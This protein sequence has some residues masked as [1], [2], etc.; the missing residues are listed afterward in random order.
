ME[1]EKVFFDPRALKRF[2]EGPLAPK[3]DGFCEW[4]SNHG[5]ARSTIRRHISR[6][7]SFS[8][9]LQK[10]KLTILV[11]VNSEHIQGVITGYLL[12]CK[13]RCPGTKHYHSVVY[14]IHRFIDYL[15]ECGFVNAV[16]HC[17]APYQSLLDEYI[18]WMKDVQRS[19][20]GTLQ[21]RAQ[22]LIRFLL[23]LG[24]DAI[25]EKLSTLSPGKIQTFFLDYSRKHG[26][27]A[28]RSM[29]AALR[30][31]L[32]FCHVQ[33]YIK[34]DLAASVP[35]LR[36]YKLD[37]LPHG[38]TDK[39]AQ[40]LLSGIDRNTDTGRRDYAI[41]QL[42]Y[43]YGIRGGQV[44]ALRLCDINWAQSQIRFAALKNGKQ[45]LQPLTNNVGEGLLDYLQNSRPPSSYPEV[46]LTLR[47]PYR[48]LQYSTT[49]SAIIARNMRAAGIKSARF[50][51]H[52]FRHGFASRMLEQ[53][54]PLKAIADMIGHR[55]I[56]TTSIYTKVDFQTLNQVPLDWPEEVL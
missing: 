44:R 6:V 10:R 24:S 43:T 11:S 46:F 45:I 16:S 38:I 4:M 15:E 28:R 12:R 34:C 32:R 27:A 17:T 42:L 7:S 1:L 47:A 51:A 23:W 19:A 30:T 25:P 41:I 22:Y 29:Q 48:P 18:K 50:G 33:G 26:R 8:R 55:C 36:T 35:T 2:G 13:H 21:L 53:G 49:L 56:Q 37:T 14:S 40:R 20:S 54:Y 3:L 52:A 5:F 39:E 9:Y 31:F